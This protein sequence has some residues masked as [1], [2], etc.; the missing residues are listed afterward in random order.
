MQL[1]VGLHV[2]LRQTLSEQIQG[3]SVTATGFARS[4]R[5]SGLHAGLSRQQSNDARALQIVE[6]VKNDRV[7]GEERHY[8]NLT[9]APS[10][11]RAR[12][13][14]TPSPRQTACDAA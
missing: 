2:D 13:S 5:Q 11:T 4:P 12:T 6:S 9:L 8:R 10:P 3:G 1:P 7:G 14:S